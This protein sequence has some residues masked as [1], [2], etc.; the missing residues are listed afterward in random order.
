[1]SDPTL[2]AIVCSQ[3]GVPAAPREGFCRNCGKQLLAPTMTA[4]PPVIPPVQ[5]PPVYAPTAYTPSAKKRRSPLMLCCLIIIGL[6][7]VALGAGG[8][9]VWRRTSYNPPVRKAPDVPQR[10]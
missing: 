4:P 3:C 9:Y 5:T 2:K 7:V 6:V 1:M 8:I 10:A